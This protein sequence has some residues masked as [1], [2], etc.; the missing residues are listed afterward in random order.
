[1]ADIPG[2][3][4]SDMEKQMLALTALHLVGDMGNLQLIAFFQETGLMN[5]F[6]L[7][8]TLYRL[9]DGG[10]AVSRQQGGDYLYSLTQG[11][12]EALTL[13]G[14][15]LPA[16]ALAAI[17]QA[18]PRF[19]R[20][21]LLERQLSSRVEHENGQEYHARLAI[22]ERDMNILSLSLSVPTP[23]MAQR[24]CDRWQANAE[25][26]YACIVSLLGGEEDA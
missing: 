26:I 3:R 19:R 22:N 12:R 8:P 24:C 14:G 11:G 23:E 18:A 25:K 13:F 7:Q 6:D 2:H 10:L 4:F 5:Y 20:K 21:V 17:E 16:S 9:R 15:S 1:M